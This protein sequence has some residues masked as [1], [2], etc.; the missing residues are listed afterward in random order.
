[1]FVWTD[2]DNPLLGIDTTVWQL[3]RFIVGACQIPTAEEMRRRNEEDALKHMQNPYIRYR[4]DFNFYTAYR[5]KLASASPKDHK[6]MKRLYRRYRDE[7]EEVYYRFLARMMEESEYPVSHGSYDELNETAQTIMKY[8]E[9]SYEHRFVEGGKA[10][11]DK[12]RT[13]RDCD[14]GDEFVSVFTGTKAVPL[15][16]RW[17]D[18]DANDES[19]LA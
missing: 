5:Q 9:M 2:V 4:M 11:K 7:E 15:K 1:M 12:P 17:L 16:H 8:N 14:D 6:R 13:F 10:G 3:L 19:I 18:M